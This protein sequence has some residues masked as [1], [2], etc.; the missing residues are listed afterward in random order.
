MHVSCRF[1]QN[2]CCFAANA[3][4][5]SGNNDTDSETECFETEEKRF[6]WK[7]GASVV[8]DKVF[9]HADTNPSATALV[10]PLARRINSR[11]SW[12]WFCQ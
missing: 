12:I 5:I 7:S 11:L 6:D 1:I 8:Y 2:S 4:M 9:L 3:E 10:L